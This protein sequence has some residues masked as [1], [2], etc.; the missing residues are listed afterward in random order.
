M[1]PLIAKSLL[2]FLS[3]RHIKPAKK[4]STIAKQYLSFDLYKNGKKIEE[5]AQTLQLEPK[6]IIIMLCADIFYCNMH[7]L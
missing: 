4:W 6:T 3:D 7:F 2:P 1:K 5:I